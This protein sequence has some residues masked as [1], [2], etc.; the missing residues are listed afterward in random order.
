MTQGFLQRSRLT[1]W[2]GLLV[3]PVAWAAHHQLGSDLIFYD[4]GLGRTGLILGLGVAMA[5][6]TVV[7]GWVSWESRHKG[8]QNGMRTFAVA[9]SALSA[10]VFL[11]ALLYQTEAALMLP[12]CHR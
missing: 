10:A 3:P 2:A 5:L 9:L 8:E 11:L 1:P 6:V 4:C 7:A 12:A